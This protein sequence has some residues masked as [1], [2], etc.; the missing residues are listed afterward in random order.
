MIKLK[1]DELIKISII[2]LIFVSYFAGF[3][4]RENLAGGA[5][6]DFLQFTWPAFKRS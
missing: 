3:N 6:E 2:F 5:E 1:I 4:L